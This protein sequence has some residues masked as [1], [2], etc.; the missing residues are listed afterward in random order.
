M[1]DILKCKTCSEYD[2]K[3]SNNELCKR[4]IEEYMNNNY[5]L[6]VSFSLDKK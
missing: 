5:I 4:C 3:L 2:Y 6:K 1:I